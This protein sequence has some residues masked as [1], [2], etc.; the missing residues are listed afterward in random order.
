MTKDEMQAMVRYGAEKIFSASSGDG[1][2]DEDIEALIAKG[3]KATEELNTKMAKYTDQALKFQ[4]DGGGDQK[5]V[6]EFE[7]EEEETGDFL[8]PETLKVRVQKRDTYQT[9]DGIARRRNL[10]SAAWIRA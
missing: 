8:D 10:A 1:I 9:R 3:V 2:T 5:D 7:D 4:L 6:Y